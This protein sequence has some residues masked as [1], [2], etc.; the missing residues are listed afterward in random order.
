MGGSKIGKYTLAQQFRFLKINNQER[1]IE[2]IKRIKDFQ[3]KLNAKINE[4]KDL[5]TDQ[6]KIHREIKDQTVL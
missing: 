3:T 5:T 6:K 4:D 2:F 1:L